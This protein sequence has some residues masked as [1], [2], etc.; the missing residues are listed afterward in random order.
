MNREK[1][2][3]QVQDI[4]REEQRAKGIADITGVLELIGTVVNAVKVDSHYMKACIQRIVRSDQQ[5]KNPLNPILSIFGLKLI[6]SR[7]SEGLE[8]A[9]SKKFKNELDSMLKLD[10]RLFQSTVSEIVSSLADYEKKNEEERTAQISKIN[11]LIDRTEQQEQQIGQ[12]KADAKAQLQTTAAWIQSVLGTFGPEG[13]EDILYERI[14]ELME[15]FDIEVFWDAQQGPLSEAVMFKEM[16]VGDIS[17]YKVK[18]C[19]IC[20]GEVLAQG[21]RF[22]QAQSGCEQSDTDD[23]A[24][25]DREQSDTGDKVQFDRGQND[26]DN[27]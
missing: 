15:F 18:P 8:V 23:K 3:L 2:N 26:T 16:K 11:E 10:E 14:C 9:E 4:V 5:S 6:R 22:C 24:Q 13:G 19:L 17:K 12:L 1:I 27:E 25:S 7:E 20:E 21:V